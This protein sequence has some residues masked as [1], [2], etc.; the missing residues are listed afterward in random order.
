MSTA[1]VDIAVPRPVE[2]FLARPVRLLI[3][4]ELVDAAWGETF[5][6]YDPAT[7]R[8]IARAAAGGAP[9]VDRAVRSRARSTGGWSVGRAQP[10]GAWTDRVADWR[11]D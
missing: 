3:G 5:P 10:V 7:G 4:G 11:V 9:E 8:E 2:D 1:P 6:V